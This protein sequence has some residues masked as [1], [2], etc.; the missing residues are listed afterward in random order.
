MADA[1]GQKGGHLHRGH[2]DPRVSKQ[3]KKTV[4]PEAT[5]QAFGNIENIV[6]VVEF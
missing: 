1:S 5:P 3:R 6:Q 4:R 2:Q